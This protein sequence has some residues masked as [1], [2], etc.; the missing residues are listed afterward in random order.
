MRMVLV[1]N[2]NDEAMLNPARRGINPPWSAAG[3]GCI[4][5]A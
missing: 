4:I 2:V 5:A 3:T 1:P